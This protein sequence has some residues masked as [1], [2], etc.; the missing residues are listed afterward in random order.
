MGISLLRTRR[1]SKV[2]QRKLPLRKRHLTC[3][4][5][6][7]QKLARLGQGG[8]FFWPHRTAF[9][10]DLSRKKSGK[11]EAL[12]QGQCDRRRELE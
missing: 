11:W 12:K 5:R 10:K 9:V 3:D 6:D 7:E 4:L 8:R 2:G 1:V